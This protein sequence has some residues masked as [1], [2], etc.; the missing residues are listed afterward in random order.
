[1]QG[2]D[3]D[4][5][6]VIFQTPINIKEI[7]NLVYVLYIITILIGQFVRNYYFLI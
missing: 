1:M 5:V 6:P 7:S 4:F 3:K 2:I